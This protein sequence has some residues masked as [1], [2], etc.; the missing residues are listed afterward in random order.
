MEIDSN[1]NINKTKAEN[2]PPVTTSEAHLVKSPDYKLIKDG[3]VAYHLAVQHEQHE[4]TK[5]IS[6]IDNLKIHVEELVI[7][8]LIVE[9]GIVAYHFW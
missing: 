8:F 5:T 4:H 9:T 7:T 1:T 2:W 6:P 3:P